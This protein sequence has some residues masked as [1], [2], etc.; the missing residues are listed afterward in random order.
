MSEH[1]PPGT[2]LGLLAALVV[3]AG[4]TACSTPSDAAGPSAAQSAPSDAAPLSSEPASGP[5]YARS[6]YEAAHVV[7]TVEGHVAFEWEGDQDVLIASVRP[8][9]GAPE[10]INLLSI[11]FDELQ[12]YEAGGWFRFAFDLVGEYAGPGGYVIRA[13]DD[14]ARASGPLSS[15]FLVAAQL[16]D[17]DGELVREN[18]ASV[19][20][21]GTV[22]EDCALEV[23]EDERAGTLDCPQLSDADGNVVSLHVAWEPPA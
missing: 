4:A 2:V 10:T 20:H 3:L 11:G 8:P 14:E 5:D 23:G 13:G 21:Y 18:L 15:A 12:E 7:V 9:P 6:T 22:L 17:R 19:A 1:R 16:R